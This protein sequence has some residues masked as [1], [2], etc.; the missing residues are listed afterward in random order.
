MSARR[1]RNRL[2]P[3]LVA[4]EDRRLLSTFTVTNTADDGS[5]GTL[6]WA[7][8]Q[9]NSTPGANTINFDATVFGTPQAI[10]LS[11]SQLELSNTS[12]T[13]TIT[14]PAAGVTVSGGGKSRVFQIDGGVPGG[15]T[16]SISGLTITDGSASNPGGG[17]LYIQ[18]TGTLT[19]NGCIV[20]GNST[21]GVG[22]G[23]F[24]YGSANLTNCTVI[25]NS[26]DGLRNAGTMTL[27]NCTVSGNSVDGLN[28]ADTMTLSGCTISANS[29]H[30]VYN[31]GKVTLTE[32]MV[33]GSSGNRRGGGL[34]NLGTMSLND[35]TISDN[36]AYFGGGLYNGATA[37]LTDCT[38]SGNSA[39]NGLGGGLMNTQGSSLVLINC[40]VSGNSARGGGALE[41]IG[42]LT[43]TDCTLSGNSGGGVYSRGTLTLTDCTVSGNSSGGSGG[44][45]CNGGSLTLIACTISGNSAPAGGGL[46]QSI[47]GAGTTLTDTIVAGNT[48]H[49]FSP[50]DIGG[51]GNVTGGY[52]LIGTG[53]GGGLTNGSN[54]NIVLTS[55]AGLGLAPLGAYGGPT[56]TIAL[57]PGSPALRA[58]EAVPPITTDQR[59]AP[60]DRPVPDIGAFQSQGFTLTPVPGSTPQATLVGTAFANPLA[61]MV[62]AKNS[63]EPISGGVIAFTAPSQGASAIL[64]ATTATI[65]AS[66][67][68][69][70]DATANSIGGSYSVT[71]SAVASAASA[72]FDLTNIAQAGFSAVSGATIAYGVPVTLSGTILAGSTAPPGSVSITVD[73]VT[74]SAP[75]QANGKFSTVFNTGGIGVGSSP[76]AIAYAYAGAVGFLGAT[77]TSQVLTVTPATPTITWPNPTDVVYGTALSNTQLDA[78]TGVPGAYNYTP[79]AGTILKTGKGQILSVTFTPT[80]TVDYTTAAATALINVLQATPNITWPNPADIVYGTPLSSAQLDA[81]ANVLG[82]FTYTPAPGTILGTGSNQALGVGFAPADTTDYTAASFTAHINVEKAQPS[83]SQLAASQSI[84]YGRAAISLAGQL[85]ASMAIP[86]G[87]HVWITVGSVS[88]H[89]TVQSDGSFTA[90][91]ATNAL[92]A[93]STAYTITYS[94]AGDVNF[95]SAVDTSTTLTINKATPT[96][97]WSN[98]AGIVY[99][100]ALSITQLDATASVPGSFAY[101]PAAGTILAAGSKQLLTVNF[102]PTDFT[103]YTIVSASA[104]VN[105]AMAQPSFSELTP[106]QSISFGQPTVVS[107]ILA[108][109]SAIPRGAQVAITIGSASVMAT[110]QSGG[111]FSAT[112]GTNALSASSTPYPISYSYAGGANFQG[113]ND[114]FTTLTVNKAT[115]TLI[116]PNPAVITYGTPLSSTQLN[117]TASV[118]GSFAY[119]PAASAVLKVGSAQPLSVSFTPADRT[120]YSE[121]TATVTIGVTP[122]TPVLTV[123]APSGTYNGSPFPAS[124]T[125]A[126]GIPGLNNTPSANLENTTPILTYFEGANPSGASL[127]STPPTSAGIYTVVANFL[128]S[129]DYAAVESAPITFAINRGA[130]RIGF[131]TSGNSAVYGQLITMV[132][133]VTATGTPSGTVTFSDGATPL[134]T[135]PLDGSSKATFTTTS[136]L[137]GSHS[138]IA[139]YNGDADFFATQSGPALESIARATTKIVLVPHALFQRKKVVSLGLTAVIEPVAPAGGVPTGVVTFELQTKSGKKIKTNVLGTLPLNRGKATLTLNPNQV[140]N[141]TITIVYSGDRGYRASTL[142]PPKLTTSG[143]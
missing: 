91:I 36:S 26:N 136:L 88:S 120:D 43:L 42:T 132:A 20:S 32:C 129:N 55:L 89:A 141:K 102:T 93:S 84:T 14:G 39:V 108:A 76:Y 11:G 142:T 48:D 67:V 50:N 49:P 1:K 119:T 79:A 69:Q 17:G 143:L 86:T 30:G 44:G 16:A 57:L 25:G 73:G 4:L 65:D 140:L 24:N 128:G 40:T 90:T 78:S 133:T 52:N 103:D 3:E 63:G 37:T 35:C 135:V 104:H 106:S 87:E 9:A 116:W 61:V 97:A 68:A 85:T 47:R 117:A 18:A 46:Y 7:I 137:V 98:P 62:T 22:G 64:S 72:H 100:T 107:G 131:T 27:T 96:L 125:I 82:T 92:S 105:V 138:L 51:G 54:G 139:T 123:S 109:T 126:S 127:G 53:G 13:Q 122:A 56:E 38:V 31:L 21:T 12:G 23:V 58:G 45:L 83:F 75:I 28:N 94:Y 112:I 81:T 74:K 110:I 5:T 34:G 121:V 41:N 99:G 130:T 19:L 71:A 10:T 77:D 113:T 101:T 29:Y 15:V 114:T 95:S 70:V 2:K 118:A 111:F 66:G 59:G 6:R 80:D 134:A 8:T 124:V 33:S 60:L 115:P